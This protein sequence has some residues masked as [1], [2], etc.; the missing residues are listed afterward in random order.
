MWLTEPH[1]PKFVEWFFGLSCSCFALHDVTSLNLN[2]P[3]T[4]LLSVQFRGQ[5]H[6]ELVTNA[7]LRLCPALWR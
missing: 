4:L 7:T 1:P 3:R 6:Q 5:Q 2:A